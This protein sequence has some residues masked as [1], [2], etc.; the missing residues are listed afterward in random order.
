MIKNYSLKATKNR[1]EIRKRM[2]SFMDSLSLNV[3]KLDDDVRSFL[4]RTSRRKSEG[5]SGEA[6]SSNFE[7]VDSIEA[8]LKTV[9]LFQK[10]YYREAI[11]GEV[12]NVP[13]WRM[14][15]KVKTIVKIKNKIN[16]IEF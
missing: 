6:S 14:K 9:Q 4:Q 7:T 3:D 5:F 8:Q 1:N 2:T 16:F 13:S 15:E 12:V 11:R 10:A